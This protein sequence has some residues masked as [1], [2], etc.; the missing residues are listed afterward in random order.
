MSI[1]GNWF[2]TCF[3]IVIITGIAFASSL[4]GS[5]RRV[6]FNH[7][8]LRALFEG[9]TVHQ[10]TSQQVQNKNYPYPLNS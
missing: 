9:V 2:A 6:G 1:L 7:S 10:E 4:L 5:D 8:T 3:A